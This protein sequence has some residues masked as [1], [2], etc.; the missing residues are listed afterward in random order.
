MARLCGDDVRKGGQQSRLAHLVNPYLPSNQSLD[1]TLLRY[2]A[3]LPAFSAAHPGFP[4]LRLAPDAVL[5]VVWCVKLAVLIATG[6]AAW[7]LGRCARTQPR[8]SA[9]LMMALW[10]ATLYLLLPETKGRYAVYTFPAWLPLLALVAA[11]RQRWRYAVGCGLTALG[12][13]ATAGLLPDAA[14]LYGTA[15]LASVAV[16]LVLWRMAWRALPAGAAGLTSGSP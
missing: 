4:H 9:L 14:R 1:V 3:D 10:V 11:Q 16:W 13:A 6:L 8:W 5:V 15:C 7:R 2:L 12:V